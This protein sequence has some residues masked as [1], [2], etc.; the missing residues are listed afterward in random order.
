MWGAK[1]H[2][3]IIWYV[4]GIQQIYHETVEF[5]TETLERYDELTRDQNR[6]KKI[7]HNIFARKP[8]WGSQ[9]QGQE[10]DGGAQEVLQTWKSICSKHKLDQW[11]LKN[12][13][14]HTGACQLLIFILPTLSFY[15]SL[16]L[17]SSTP[18]SAC[19]CFICLVWCPI[20]QGEH[21]SKTGMEILYLFCT[22]LTSAFD[23][24]VLFNQY[25]LV[26]NANVAELKIFTRPS[27]TPLAVL[28]FL[29]SN[30]NEL[31]CKSRMSS[32]IESV[33]SYTDKF[34]HVS[35]S[36]K[37]LL[38]SANSTPLLV[39]GMET[40]NL[41]HLMSSFWVDYGSIVNNLRTQS[42]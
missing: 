7:V 42:S 32:A 31:Q 5:N 18:I 22:L 37:V 12:S 28:H 17:S 13:T 25:W 16:F 30:A 2:V 3:P 1:S 4:I 8:K 33:T 27:C 34:A 26:F 14:S 9:R 41:I 35:C 21:S 11:K 36:P 20:P 10:G 40:V 24:I 38:T 29:T 6:M 15:H 39:F 19:S 23:F